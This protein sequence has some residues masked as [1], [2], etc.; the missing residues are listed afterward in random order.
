VKEVEE[1]E[2]VV[3]QEGHFHYK[4]CKHDTEA[5]HRKSDCACG[6]RVRVHTDLLLEA[7][8]A[9]RGRVL[10]D[11]P[12]LSIADA[13]LKKHKGDNMENTGQN[14]KQR[15]LPLDPGSPLEQVTPF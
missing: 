4:G 14:K 6:T 5:D 9:S 8:K 2:K 7:S 15:P 1:K 12:K 13:N 3:Y 11:K 10:A